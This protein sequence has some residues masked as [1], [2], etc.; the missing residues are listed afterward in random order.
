MTSS[1][2][3]SSPFHQRRPYTDL[4][5]RG[6]VVAHRFLPRPRRLGDA[7]LTTSTTKAASVGPRRDSD[8]ALRRQTA[9]WLSSER[10]PDAA[11]PAGLRSRAPAVRQ[12]RSGA[13]RGVTRRDAG[14][15][16][17]ALTKWGGAAHARSRPGTGKSAFPRTGR[18]GS[19]ARVGRDAAREAAAIRLRTAGGT[20]AVRGRRARRRRRARARAAAGHRTARTSRRAVR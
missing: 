13:G 20:L 6:K 11:P 8:S 14:P 7:A 12:P 9:R 15:V 18:S 17:S 2:S 4:G 16:G 1:R 19:V 3:A 5:R 10:A